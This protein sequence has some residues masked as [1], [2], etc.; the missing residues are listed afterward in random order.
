MISRFN[1]LFKG[2]Y[3]KYYVM[4]YTKEA[5]QFVIDNIE[6]MLNFDNKVYK[7]KMNLDNQFKAWGKEENSKLVEMYNAGYSVSEMALALKRGERGI[8][9]RLRKNGINVDE[10]PT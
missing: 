7:A 3:G 8:K 5:Q 2:V 6:A 4:L 10:I 1:K 9:V